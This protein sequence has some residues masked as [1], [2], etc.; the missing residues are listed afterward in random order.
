MTANTTIHASTALPHAEDPRST[1]DP[2]WLIPRT[3]APRED[4]LDWVLAN[5]PVHDAEAFAESYRALLSK[6]AQEFIHL[7]SGAATE[8][9]SRYLWVFPKPVQLA[10]SPH[11]LIQ[12]ALVS[13]FF[14]NLIP[15]ISARTNRLTVSINGGT[16]RTITLPTGIYSAETLA[17]ALDPLIPEIQIALDSTSTRMQFTCATPFAFSAS[18]TLLGPLGF[19][20]AGTLTVGHVEVHQHRVESVAGHREQHAAE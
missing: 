18:S 2:R 10:P 19:A 8:Q 1:I 14:W 16:A 17:Q 6:V 13:F 12:V 4:T 15:N 9:G 3:E 7:D 11:D 20:P 5:F